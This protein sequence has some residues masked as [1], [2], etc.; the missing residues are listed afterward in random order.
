MNKKKNKA[1]AISGEIPK[2]METR[3]L[4]FKSAWIIPGKII[5]LIGFI[6]SAGME[7][8]TVILAENAQTI[9]KNI[10]T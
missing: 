8:S 2:T 10:S 9:P 7:Y 4:G 5:S 6:I 1:A 3:L